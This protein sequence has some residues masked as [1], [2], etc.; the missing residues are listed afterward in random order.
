[1]QITTARLSK[2]LFETDPMHTACAENDCF[3][4]YDSVAE[5]TINLMEKG[6]AFDAALHQVFSEFFF[7]DMANMVDYSII[8]NRLKN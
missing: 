3:D 1:M 4:E 6:M 7:E 2:V 8:E 5:W